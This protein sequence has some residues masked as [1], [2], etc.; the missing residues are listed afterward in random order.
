MTIQEVGKFAFA[1]DEEAPPPLRHLS[2]LCS[3]LPDHFNYIPSQV[4]VPPFPKCYRSPGEKRAGLIF[5]GHGG[6]N[7]IVHP[8][9]YYFFCSIFCIIKFGSNCTIF[10]L[11]LLLSAHSIYWMVPSRF[12]RWKL[13]SF[14]KETKIFPAIHAIA[15][16]LVLANVN[17]FDGGERATHS[18]H[19][20]PPNKSAERQQHSLWWWP[21]AKVSP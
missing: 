16:D 7:K 2:L 6:D 17:W 8:C 5:F 15:D 4:K 9:L 18:N 21:I 3:T 1:E 14:G 12:Q 10:L 19:H 13:Y 11:L 20:H